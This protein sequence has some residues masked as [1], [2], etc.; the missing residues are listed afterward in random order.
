MPMGVQQTS[1][2]QNKYF[3]WNLRPKKIYRIKNIEACSTILSLPLLDRKGPKKL[4]RLFFHI[5]CFYTTLSCHLGLVSWVRLATSLLVVIT[6]ILSHLTTLKGR[7]LKDNNIAVVFLCTFQLW[8]PMNILE[9]LQILT[10]IWNTNPF[11]FL[12]L[13][14]IFHP[15]QCCCKLCFL[16]F[17]SFQKH[18]IKTTFY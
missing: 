1:I 8:Q 6:I 5:L 18:Y 11:D 10:L 9:L 17:L 4:D 7:T 12:R 2:R 16:A 3:T 15:F 14:R 13:W